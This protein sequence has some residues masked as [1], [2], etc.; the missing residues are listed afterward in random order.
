MSL[1]EMLPSLRS[2][3]QN[4]KLRLMQF[5]AAELAQESQT[6]L[7]AGAIY[8]L[9]TPQDIPDTAAE[10]LAAYLKQTESTR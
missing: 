10:A 1:R 6:E 3:S 8:P 9:Y 4:D 5:L 7:I 2:L